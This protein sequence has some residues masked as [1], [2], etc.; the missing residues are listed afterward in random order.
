[1]TQLEQAV[2]VYPQT[3]RTH[4]DPIRSTGK[5]W[6]ERYCNGLLLTDTAAIVTGVAAAQVIRFG[7]SGHALLTDR[8]LISNTLVSAV[9][10]LAWCV[11]LPMFRSREPQI[12]GTGVEEYRRV[13]NASFAL[14]GAVAVIAYLLKLD[15]AR[16]YLVVA[17]PLGLLLLLVSRRA[18][19]RLAAPPARG[20]EVLLLGAGRRLAQGR[21]RHGRDLRAR[22]RR[23]LPCGRRVRARLGQRRQGPRHRRA[24]RP[25]P[26]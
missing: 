12:V 11:A 16:G 5:G 2:P 10:V 9:L 1:M 18:W 26:G 3:G 13:A 6:V 4:E 20:P 7:T 8:T 21:G 22:P 17:L 25:G 23:R 19:R 24:P 15:I 14:F